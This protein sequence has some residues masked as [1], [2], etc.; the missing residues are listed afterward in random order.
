M[1]FALYLPLLGFAVSIP[2]QTI[3]IDLNHPGNYPRHF[4]V[5]PADG[6]KSAKTPEQIDAVNQKLADAGN[7]EAAW[8]LGLAYLQGVGVKQD[9][10]QAK[11]WFEIGATKPEQ[12]A[13][14]AEFYQ[15]GEYFPKDLD[16]AARW[17]TAAGRPGDLFA[18][19]ENDRKSDPPQIANAVALYRALLSQTGH[20]EVR[21]AQM[22]LGNLVL[23]GRYSAGDDAAGHRLNLEWARVITQELLGQEEYKIAVDYDVDREGLPK[24]HAMWLLFC[25]RAARYNID[26]AQQNYGHAVLDHEIPGASPFEG[27]AWIRLASDKQYANKVTVQ[28]LERQM[29][30]PQLTQATSIYD[31]FVQTR[32]Q[33]GAYYPAND[34]LNRPSE[35]ALSKMPDDDPDV[36]L[37]RAFALESSRNPADYQRA[38]QMYRTVRDRRK[39]DV[40]VVLGRDYLLGTNGYKQDANTARFWLRMAASEGSEPAKLLLANLGESASSPTASPAASQERAVVT[41]S[42][43]QSQAPRAEVKPM[44]I[45]GSVHPPVV[46]HSVNPEFSEQ[47]RQEKFSGS[48]QVYLWVDENGDPKHVRVVRGVGK[49]LDEEAVEAIRQ[50]KFKPATRD[51]KAVT[52]DLYIDVN[53]QIVDKKR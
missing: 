23:D 33:S 44:H 20:P 1:K 15:N 11:H 53:F 51:G 7:T 45:G 13:F 18:L 35:T 21:R 34:P 24:D 48:V 39:M 25:E 43:I 46:I 12:K 3:K 42:E 38:M 37:R 8:Q 6:D 26:L 19:A 50:Y 52:V 47:A 41:L 10:D 9:L 49:G 17:F 32:E 5:E 27:Y 36:Q 31:G 14:V 22:E 4:S 2:G 29:T 28:Q 30:P 40:R 16:A